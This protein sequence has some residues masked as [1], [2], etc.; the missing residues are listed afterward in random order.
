MNYRLSIENETYPVEELDIPLQ[1]TFADNLSGKPVLFLSPVRLPIGGTCELLAASVGYRLLVNTCLEFP[2]SQ[3]FL[4]T[5]IIATKA[6]SVAS[7]S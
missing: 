6:M 5:G 1:F 4:V 7:P 2:A 3:R